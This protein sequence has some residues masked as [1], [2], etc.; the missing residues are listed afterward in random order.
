[1]QLNSVVEWLPQGYPVVM[2]SH[3]VTQHGSQTGQQLLVFTE[4]HSALPLHHN[5][6]HGCL[7][8]SVLYTV[9]QL[10]KP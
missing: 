3:R 6:E 7:L 9:L 5:M 1:M 4:L 2:A 8:L 10:L